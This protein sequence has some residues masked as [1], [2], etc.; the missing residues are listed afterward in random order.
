MAADSKGNDIGAV[1]IPVTGFAA[2]NLTA[3]A[4][5]AMA[6]LKAD[7][8]PSGYTYLGLFTEDGGYAEETD[9]GDTIEFF[10][11]GYSLKAGDESLKGSITFAENSDLLRQLLGYDAGTSGTRK[12]TLR[13]GQFGLVIATTHKN[14]KTLI[15]G[16]LASVD[17]ASVSQEKRGDVTTM[18]VTFKWA[19]DTTTGFYRWKVL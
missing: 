4:V 17:D 15:R 2:I 11:Q 18:E 16:G 5:P 7:T 12:T 3:T 8:L 1:P 14:G 6:D 13:Q 10:Q 19:W 9:T